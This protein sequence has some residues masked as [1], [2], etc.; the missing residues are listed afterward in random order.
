MPKPPKFFCMQMKGQIARWVLWFPSTSFHIK[1]AIWDSNNF[2]P[3]LGNLK[4]EIKYVGK[5]AR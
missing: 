2:K 3:N 4:K 1:L 5:L